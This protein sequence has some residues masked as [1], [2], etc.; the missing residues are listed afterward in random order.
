MDEDFAFSYHDPREEYD[1]EQR[2]WEEHSRKYHEEHAEEL[3]QLRAK[4]EAS[5][6]KTSYFDPHSMVTGCPGPGV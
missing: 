4:Q 6:W 2:E 5:I 3:A 1:K